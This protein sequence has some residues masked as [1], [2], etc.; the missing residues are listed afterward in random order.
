MWEKIL[1]SPTKTASPPLDNFSHT[2]SS[3]QLKNVGRGKYEKELLWL[4]EKD[5]RGYFFKKDKGQGLAG[6]GQVVS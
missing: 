2:S 3:R 6:K 1:R 5:K 4:E